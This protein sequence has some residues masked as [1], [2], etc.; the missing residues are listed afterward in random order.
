MIVQDKTYEISVAAGKK[1]KMT[2]A[3]FSLENAWRCGWDY[4]AVSEHCNF[5]GEADSNIFC[6]D[7]G[8]KWKGAAG[9][10]LWVG[11]ASDGHQPD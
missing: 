11:E 10:V 1:I 3:A 9:Q 4:L 5:L 8:W 7:R 2:F 6:S